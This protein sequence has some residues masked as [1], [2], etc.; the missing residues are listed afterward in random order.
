METIFPF[1]ELSIKPY[2]NKDRGLLVIILGTKLNSH[3]WHI[4]ITTFLLFLSPEAANDF[5]VFLN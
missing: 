1:M 3:R 5:G 4:D 2:M